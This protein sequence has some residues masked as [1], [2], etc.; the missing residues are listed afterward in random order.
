[1]KIMTFAICLCLICLAYMALTPKAYC[2]APTPPV[3]GA[4]AAPAVCGPVASA[5]GPAGCA[6]CGASASAR[7]R[8]V[9]KAVDKLLGFSR[10]HARRE[11]RRSGS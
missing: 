10:R 2:D 8:R 9:L 6:S 11:A 7:P 3:A 5:C 4:C 1:M